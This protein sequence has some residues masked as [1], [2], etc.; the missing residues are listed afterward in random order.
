[1]PTAEDDK[2]LECTLLPVDLVASSI[3]DHRQKEH[4]FSLE[5]QQMSPSFCKQVQSSQVPAFKHLFSNGK[6]PKKK[7]MKTTCNQ[8]LNFKKI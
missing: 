3:K 7:K 2:G 4:W 5:L 6:I 1:M 8:I